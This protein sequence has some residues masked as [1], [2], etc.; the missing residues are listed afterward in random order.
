MVQYNASKPYFIDD[1]T[2]ITLNIAKVQAHYVYYL[3][4]V[5]NDT[6]SALIKSNYE[7]PLFKV[8]Y[9]KKTLNTSLIFNFTDRNTKDVVD[10]VI[11]LKND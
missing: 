1:P 7:N 5:S 9:N 4:A 3:P 10:T 8:Y 6:T 11:T 2:N